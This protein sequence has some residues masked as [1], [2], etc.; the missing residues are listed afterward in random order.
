MCPVMEPTSVSTMKNKTIQD[1]CV[2]PYSFLTQI[3]SWKLLSQIV[4]P[5]F[6]NLQHL[7]LLI[8]LAAIVVM[9]FI[10]DRNCHH[11]DKT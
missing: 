9:K 11:P 6:D 5:G 8:V 1:C 10:D 7:C 3:L 2:T 4:L